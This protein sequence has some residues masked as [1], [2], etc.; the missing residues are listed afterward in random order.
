[1]NKRKVARFMAHGVDRL[2]CVKKQLSILYRANHCEG[3]LNGWAICA[4]TCID[5]LV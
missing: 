1:M 2:G 5:S 3:L 4:C